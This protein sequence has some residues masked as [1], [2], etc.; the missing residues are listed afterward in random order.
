M[1]DP[2]TL[3]LPVEERY[4]ALAPDL[5]RK[6]MEIAG[7]SASDANALADE[8][9]LALDQLATAE[10]ADAEIQLVF[11]VD[12][13]GVDVHVRCGDRSAM[14]AKALPASKS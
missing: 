3:V 14:V 11:H 9:R 10:R 8:L 6:Y 4:R 12:P 5:A 13:R 7:G 1:S 2:V